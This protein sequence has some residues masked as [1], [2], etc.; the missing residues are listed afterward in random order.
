LHLILWQYYQQQEEHAR[1]IAAILFSTQTIATEQRSKYC[2]SLRLFFNWIR[3]RWWLRLAPEDRSNAQFSEAPPQQAS[4]S[5][6]YRNLELRAEHAAYRLHVQDSEA[7]RA[8]LRARAT[9]QYLSQLAQPIPPETRAN[10]GRLLLGLIKEGEHAQ[11]HRVAEQPMIVRTLRLAAAARRAWEANQFLEL[12]GAL[13][14]MQGDQAQRLASGVEHWLDEMKQ[15]AC[16][17]E[18]LLSQ[19]G[20]V[21]ENERFHR[22]L[23]ASNFVDAARRSVFQFSLDY[24]GGTRGTVRRRGER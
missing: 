18:S 24:C 3:A 17:L 13:K 8:R 16:L 6:T 21:E 20:K 5:S 1:R 11:A 12:V 2:I 23:Q 19:Q 22:M 10:A 9:E 7:I 14:P 15:H 4:D